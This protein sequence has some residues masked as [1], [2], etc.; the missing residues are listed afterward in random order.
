[1]NIKY[2]AELSLALDH[3]RFPYTT[4][5][6]PPIDLSHMVNGYRIVL[7]HDPCADGHHVII[8]IYPTSGN[9][10][11][12]ALRINLYRDLL[13]ADPTQD[14][15][16]SVALEYTSRNFHSC[17]ETTGFMLT[18]PGLYSFA[19]VPEDADLSSLPRTNLEETLRSILDGPS[20]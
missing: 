14:P 18:E 16:K 19:A 1:M 17:W 4:R 13:S 5:R 12:R 10:D 8:R 15:L 6:P 2:A 11:L 3:V 9:P 20:S 7:E